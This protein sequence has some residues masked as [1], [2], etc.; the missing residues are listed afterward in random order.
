VLN[1]SS[2]A[3]RPLI[4]YGT[5]LPIGCYEGRRYVSA[6]EGRDELMASRRTDGASRNLGLKISEQL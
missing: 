5:P 1:R 3:L 2:V 4:V 6:D